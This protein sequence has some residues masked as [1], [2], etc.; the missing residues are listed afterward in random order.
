MGI[1]ENVV[2]ATLLLFTVCVLLALV[3]NICAAQ[4]PQTVSVNSG[5]NGGTGVLAGT[6]DCGKMRIV[7]S[8]H[9]VTG[10]KSNGP[11]CYVTKYGERYPA[12]VQGSDSFSDAALLLIWNKG[13]IR[14]IPDAKLWMGDIREGDRVRTEGFAYFG[15]YQ[16]VGEVVKTTNRDTMLR[17][18]VGSYSGMS[19]GAS[20]IHGESE[21]FVLTTTTGTDGQ[22]SVGPY[23]DFWKRWIPTCSSPNY[24]FRVEPDGGIGLGPRI[25]SQRPSAASGRRLISAGTQRPIAANCPP[26][27]T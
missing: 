17:W 27:G 24:Q 25:S 7:L 12:T 3:A 11:G 16:Q 6:S 9:H 4:S 14:D 1:K 2:L 20:F 8:V 5:N 26:G 22:T 15:Y 18:K 19:G 13:K 21:P 10:P 23:R